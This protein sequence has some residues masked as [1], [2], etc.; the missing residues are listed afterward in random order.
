MPA[1]LLE[2]LTVN[3]KEIIKFDKK[4]FRACIF[5]NNILFINTYCSYQ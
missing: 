2:L 1:L 5:V 4:K 3:M